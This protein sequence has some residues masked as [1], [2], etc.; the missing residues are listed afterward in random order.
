MKK[1]DRNTTEEFPLRVGISTCLLGEKVRFDAGH[2]RDRYLTD[3][4]GAYMEWVPVCPEVEVGM[5]VPRESVRLVGSESAPHMVG[6]K[7]ESDWTSRMNTYSLD[8]VRRLHDLKLS[9]Y[10]L[11]SD[12]P[13]CGMERVKI[14]SKEGLPSRKGTGLFAKALMACYPHLPVE[15]EGR[16]NDASLR[17]NFIERVFCYHRLQ[18]DVLDQFTV[19][20]LVRFHTVHKYLMLSHSPK[21]YDTLGRL[22]ARAKELPRSA[23]RENYTKLFMEG[24]KE[25]ATVKKHTNVLQHVLGFLK[26]V[27]TDLEKRSIL[28][29]IED[30]HREMVPLI[31]PVTLLRHYI[32]K[33]DVPWIRDQVYLHPHPKEL[34]LRNHV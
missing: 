10:I 25:K 18:R 7:S 3:V 23:V 22:V 29:T 32:V 5:G 27:L 1:N 19:G 34:M 26:D 12:S 6:T 13:S 15:E 16:L 31:V 24:L 8:R 20:N 21:H 30:Y 33:R 11:K 14:Y 2:K 17:E 28:E 9:G 4:L